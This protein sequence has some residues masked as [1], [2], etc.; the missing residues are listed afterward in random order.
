MGQIR[1]LVGALPALVMTRD[2]DRFTTRNLLIYDY[3]LANPAGVFAFRK[4]DEN[5]CRRRL[6][7]IEIPEEF[8][9]EDKKRLYQFGMDLLALA[10]LCHRIRKLEKKQQPVP[11]ETLE[12]R[13]LLESELKERS[14][15]LEVQPVTDILSVEAAIQVWWNQ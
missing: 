2:A 9:R 8:I 11:S 1:D 6:M 7:P 10:G 4:G 5:E 15:T 3:E 12:E 14:E 13:Y